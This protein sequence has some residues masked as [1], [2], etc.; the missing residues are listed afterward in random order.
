MPFEFEL[1]KTEAR[2]KSNGM[3]LTFKP[4]SKHDLEYLRLLRNNNHRHF[5]NN[6]I[7]G[8]T[9]HLQWYKRYRFNIL[10]T[11]FVVKDFHTNDR[12]GCCAVY[13]LDM[14]KQTVKIGR[15]IVESNMRGFGIGNRMVNFCVTFATRVY[16]VRRAILL[17]VRASN[18]KAISL[19]KDNHFEIV[20]QHRGIIEMERKVEVE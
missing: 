1:A 10:D 6:K 8:P 15:F 14:E 5:L 19:Y 11:M 12:Y 7:I 20:R 17:E 13:D 9:Q 18:E 3:V 4:I 2:K 16:K